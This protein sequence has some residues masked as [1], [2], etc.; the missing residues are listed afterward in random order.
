[1]KKTLEKK[2]IKH[3]YC[4]VHPPRVG[5]IGGY[6]VKDVANLICD[7]GMEVSE[8]KNYRQNNGEIVDLERDEISECIML[9]AMR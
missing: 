3:L 9:Y 8:F 5:I 7:S 6:S 2:T 4:E 1:M